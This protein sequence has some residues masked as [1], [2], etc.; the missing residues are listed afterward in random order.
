[1]T[2]K[3]IPIV[4]LIAT[5]V[6]SIACAYIVLPEG[7]EASSATDSKGWRA[8]PTNVATSEG[9]ALHVDLTLLNETGDWSAMRAAEGAPAVL[10]IGGVDHTCDTVF[11][12]TGGHR[13]APGFQLRGYTAGTKAEPRIQMVYVEC[14]G[15]APAP[16]ST[17]TVNYSYVTGQYNYYEQDK[18]RV[19]TSLEVDLDQVAGDLTYPVGDPVDGLIQDPGTVIQAINKVTLQLTDVQRTANGLEFAWKTANPGEYPSYVHIGNPPVI[20]DDGI[21]CGFYETPDIVSVPITGAGETAE[22]TTTV[23]VPPE[24]HGLYIMLSVETG[25]ARLFANYAID[26]TDR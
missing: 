10:H 2:R 11:V 14:A 12:G 20:G 26:V 22:W 25:K 7:L 4:V 6:S 13:V 23:A 18:G 3:P 21:L 19:D 24:V 1:M 5:L 9:G 16:G 17:L 8:I 15:A